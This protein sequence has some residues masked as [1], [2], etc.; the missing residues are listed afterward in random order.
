[1]ERNSRSILNLLSSTVSEWLL[2][3]LLFVDATFS[4]LLKKFATSCKLQ[5]PCLLCSRLDHVLGNE[6]PKFYRRLLC[7]DHRTE[8]SSLIT[9]HIH[10]KLVDAREMCEECLMSFA[11]GNNSSTESSRILVGKLGFDLNHY[12]F[13]S[14]SLHKNVLHGSLSAKVCSCCGNLWRA[15]S[16]A[17]RFLNLTPLGLGS[18]KHN[19]KPPLPRVPSRSRLSHRDNF[20]KLRDK[21]SEPLTPLCI[22][23]T[24]VESLSH[25]GYTELKITSDTE[26]EFQFTDDDDA[27][28][29]IHDRTDD[30]EVHVIQHSSGIV[31]RAHNDN[32]DLAKQTQETTT[33]EPSLSEQFVQLY[34][35]NTRDVKSSASANI[36][37]LGLEDLNWEQANLNPKTSDMH[38]PV[39]L[40]GIPPSTVLKVHGS[41]SAN[42]SAVPLSQESSLSA[43]SELVSPN[44][45][46]T[47]LDIPLE[48]LPEKL[49]AIRAKEAKREAAIK[50][51]ELS[52]SMA[53]TTAE[54]FKTDQKLN[55]FSSIMLHFSSPRDKCK[56]NDIPNRREVSEMPAELAV[57][58][59][60]EKVHDQISSAHGIGQSLSDRSSEMH[61][62]HRDELQKSDDSSSSIIGAP[63][64][65]SSLEKRNSFGHE[66]VDGSGTSDTEGENNIDSLK[67]Q[68]DHYKRYANDLYKEL[69]EERNA[70][71]IA[72]NQ[73][74]AMITRLQE[75]KASLRMEALQ[76]LRMMEEQAEHDMEALEKANDLLADKE[77]EMQDLEAELEVYRINYPEEA[78]LE[79]IPGETSYPE[80]YDLKVEKNLI[81]QINTV[82]SFKSMPTEVFEGGDED[83][84]TEDSFSNIEDMKIYILQCLEKLEAKLLDLSGDMEPVYMPNGRSPENVADGLKNLET[85]D[86]TLTDHQKESKG[87][88]L[89]TEGS[90]VAIEGISSV[91]KESNHFHSDQLESS[92]SGR[93]IDVTFLENEILDLNKRLGAFEADH[94]FLNHAFNLVQKGSEGLVFVQEI[95]QWLQ[96][97]RKIGNE[98]KRCPSIM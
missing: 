56:S 77:K 58:N 49:D 80:A 71:A 36:I 40:D 89:T 88:I 21:F 55:G 16:S 13:E 78:T 54:C 1:M 85:N 34:A 63:Q 45:I 25:V 87:S 65:S 50:H 84:N 96:D 12:V 37:G 98:I 4:Y 46:L 67:R 47:L 39:A 9:C 11:T 66:S 17:Q 83:N 60:V 62:H 93:E 8:I 97:L 79:N 42:G 27:S 44:G 10:G 91:I 70:S 32:V 61:G 81:P 6:N 92:A 94:D 57:N 31:P 95:A 14:P 72:A 22:G 33:S 64:T 38:E 69:E 30:K 26:S 68:V 73:A 24:G 51:A 43:V 74:M 35:G 3:F 52:E 7:G 23:N 5:T 15:R 48:A 59:D 19:V 75:E 29:V 53:T 18:A 90:G 76:Y 20:K 2:I 86:E 82:L 41:A 28:S